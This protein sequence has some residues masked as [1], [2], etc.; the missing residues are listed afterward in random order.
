M[1]ELYF[2]SIQDWRQVCVYVFFNLIMNQYLISHSNG[3]SGM[4]RSGSAIIA[5]PGYGAWGR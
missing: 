5:A 2:E 1:D 3:G 4:E